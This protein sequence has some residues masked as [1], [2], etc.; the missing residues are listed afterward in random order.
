MNVVLTGFGKMG[1]EIYSVLENRGHNVIGVID[2]FSLDKRVTNKTIE[3]SCFENA[4]VVIDFS[5]PENAVENIKKYM[6]FSIPAII[7]TTG[8]LDGLDCVKA[9]GEGKDL[10]IMYSGNY[11]IGV[12]LFLKLCRKAGELYGKVA[13]YD[14]SIYEI[15]HTEKKDSPSG[16]ALMVASA[17]METMEGKKKILLG[18]SEGKIEKDSL[19]ISSMRV[20]K[21]PGVHSV[22]IDSDADTITLTHTAR[23]RSGFALGAVMAAEWI[24]DTTKRGIL[25]LDDYLNET[26]GE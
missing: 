13:G 1:K 14:A 5:S 12:A 15:H 17:L 20:G 4:D 9:Y 19:Q 6:D 18:N 22:I 23:S 26:F 21:T 7:G 2:P 16:T 24:K 25:T 10:R 8:W 3:A 11:S